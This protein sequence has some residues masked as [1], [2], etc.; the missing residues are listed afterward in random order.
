MNFSND[1]SDGC[2]TYGEG[3][4]GGSINKFSH[5]ITSGIKEYNKL[6]KSTYCQIIRALSIALSHISS[7]RFF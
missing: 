1:K 5:L 4:G 7:P 6:L 3:R 2:C